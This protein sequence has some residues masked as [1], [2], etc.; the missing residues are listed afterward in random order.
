VKAFVHKARALQ[1]QGKFDEVRFYKHHPF[2]E[3]KWSFIFPRTVISKLTPEY[4]NNSHDAKKDQCHSHASLRSNRSC[5]KRKKFGPHKGVFCIWAVQKIG[6]EQKGA[7]V[8]FFAQPTPVLANIPSMETPFVRKTDYMQI[9]K[10]VGTFRMY[11]SL[12]FF[13]GCISFKECY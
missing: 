13:A 10:I 2:Y 3:L 4:C 11:S 9:I 5:T 7:L 6:W 8:T 12:P 1:A